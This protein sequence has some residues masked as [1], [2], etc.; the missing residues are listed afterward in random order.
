MSG[1]HPPMLPQMM[2]PFG[3]SPA[4]GMP[5]HFGPPPPFSMSNYNYPI[6]SAI[7]SN[8]NSFSSPIVTNPNSHQHPPM[9]PPHTTSQI[10][11]GQCPPIPPDEVRSPYFEMPAGIMTQHVKLEDFDY[12]SIDSDAMRIPLIVPPSEGLIKAIEAFYAPPSHEHPRSVDG[13]EKL[14]LYEFF[15]IKSQARKD[16]ELKI[17]TTDTGDKENEDEN[18]L[19][20]VSNDQTKPPSPKRKFKQFKE[21]RDT[22]FVF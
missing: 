9:M 5:Q 19:V 12:Q 21:E 10:P 8:V 20:K 3:S 1:N 11:M 4:H 6:T 15:K 17:G 13:W 18:K 7:T 22:R 2:P 14:G 16:Y